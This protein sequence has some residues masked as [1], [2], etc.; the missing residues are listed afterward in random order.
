MSNPTWVTAQNVKFNGTLSDAVVFNNAS[1]V[2]TLALWADLPGV[3]QQKLIDLV[4][5]YGNTLPLAG[6]VGAK[7]DLV[8]VPG[9]VGSTATGLSAVS[10]AI[11]GKAIVDLGASKAGS[12]PSGLSSSL[13]TA[14]YGLANYQPGVVGSTNLGLAAPV[15]GSQIVNFGGTIVGANASGLANTGTLYTMTV[16]V[17]GVAKPISIV[18]SA[19]Q[20]FT[21]VVSEINA[22]LGASATAAIVAGN[23]KITSATTGSSSTVLIANGTLLNALTGYVSI[24]PAIN[25]SGA[26]SYAASVT[27]DGVAYPFTVDPTVTTTFTQLLSAINSAITTHGTATLTGGDLRITSATFGTASK[28]RISAGTLFPAT[29]GFVNI[30]PAADGGGS[31]R[32][33]SAQVLVDGTK[34]KSVRFLGTQGTTL[35][36]VIS[37]INAD[38]GADATAAITGGDIVITSATTGKASSV[39]VYDAGLFSA[40]TGFT[41]V[42]SVAGD[43]PTTYTAQVLLTNNGVVTTKSIS[44]DGNTAQTITALVSALTTQLGSDVTVT[45]TSSVIT[46]TNAKGITDGATT[47]TIRIVR[48]TLFPAVTP[49]RSVSLARPLV[50]TFLDVLNNTKTSNGSSFYSTLPIQVV[51]A[52]PAV[53]PYVKHT[54]DYIY[55]NGTAFA[56]LDNDAV[57]NA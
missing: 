47:S 51:G 24:S 49:I 40:L 22:D 16:T 12:D 25:G 34:L 19:A 33:Y 44:I 1:G 23:L 14:G 32:N 52:K 37:E 55:F 21:S 30:I 10:S 53:P 36:N 17:D 6:P 26:T 41:S 45:L 11:A 7:Q 9:T 42:V 35:T 54:L 18:G 57:V 31:A 8:L 48:G 46:L 13:G 2:R 5:Q 15:A 39:V 29:V 38:L 20:T 3:D 50:A 43:A 27:I 56:Y 28:V 4:A